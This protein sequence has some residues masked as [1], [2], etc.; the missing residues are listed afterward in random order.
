MIKHKNIFCKICLFEWFEQNTMG[1]LQWLD[2]SVGKK[3]AGFMTGLGR[4]DVMCQNPAN[5]ILHMGHSGGE[6]QLLSWSSMV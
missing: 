3:V 1:Y 6:Y 2:V 5:A 4:L